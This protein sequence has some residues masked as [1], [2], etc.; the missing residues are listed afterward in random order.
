MQAD[1][2]DLLKFL[3]CSFRRLMSC[4]RKERVAHGAFHFKK[5]SRQNKDYL[6]S[7]EY[8][9]SVKF[10]TKWIMNLESDPSANG[11]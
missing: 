11:Q 9:A 6:D 7:A 4:S 5:L 2:A 10:R 3:G 8:N 1:P